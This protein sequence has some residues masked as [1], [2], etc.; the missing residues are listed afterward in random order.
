MAL[1]STSMF[2]PMVRAVL[3]LPVT[4]TVG[5]MGAPM[6][7]PRPVEKMM[8]WAPPAASPVI[9]SHAAEGVFITTSPFRLGVSE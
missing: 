6:A 5:A 3:G 1:T 8:I 9:D 2:S 4:L 7:L